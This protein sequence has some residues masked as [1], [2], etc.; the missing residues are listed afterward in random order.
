MRALLIAQLMNYQTDIIRLAVQSDSDQ[1]IGSTDACRYMST[2]Y[3]PAV[4]D[5]SRPACLQRECI[6]YTAA[7]YAVVE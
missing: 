1:F 4:I 2:P 6:N 3:V 7:I 5:L